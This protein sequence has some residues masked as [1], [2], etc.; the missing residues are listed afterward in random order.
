MCEGHELRGSEQA[1]KQWSGS[2]PA[3][4]LCRSL[5]AEA[6]GTAPVAVE[7]DPVG[8]SSIGRGFGIHL[9]ILGILA[10]LY[11]HPSRPAAGK[12]T[13]SEAVG[14]DSAVVVVVCCAAGN[15]LEGPVGCRS[16]QEP[17]MIHVDRMPWLRSKSRID[18]SR[19]SK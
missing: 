17:D 7:V 15:L 3:L 19:D 14:K 12:N 16:A 8:G 18:E 13:D 11:I 5:V 10:R 4:E 6:A 2:L 1:P 9:H